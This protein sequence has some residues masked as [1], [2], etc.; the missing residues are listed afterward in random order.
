ML[1]ALERLRAG[2]EGRLV[3]VDPLDQAAP[4]LWLES[5]PLTT[6]SLEGERTEWK[7]AGFTIQVETIAG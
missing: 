1:A 5:R 2:D 7:K 6:T 4:K 3:A